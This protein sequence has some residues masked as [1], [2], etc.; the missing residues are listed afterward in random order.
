MK[1]S[2]IIERIATIG[3][4]LTI[5][6]IIWRWYEHDQESW[7]RFNAFGQQAGIAWHEA[8]R[9]DPLL[10]GS[11][12]AFGIA[13]VWVMAWQLIETQRITA[14]RAAPDP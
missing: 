14:A 3:G 13:T 9:W 1:F 11:L 5:P 4:I 6:M 2:E 12:I 8:H 7:R 10:E